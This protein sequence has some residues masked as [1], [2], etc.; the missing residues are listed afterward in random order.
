MTIDNVLPD[1]D[2]ADAVAIP[3]PSVA[4]DSSQDDDSAKTWS[5]KASREPRPWGTYGGSVFAT[6]DSRQPLEPQARAD[7]SHSSPELQPAAA[8]SAASPNAPS[9]DSEADFESEN[10]PH[11]RPRPV[12]IDPLGSAACF[13]LLF[14]HFNALLKGWRKEKAATDQE[15]LSLVAA[16]TFMRLF[17]IARFPVFGLVTSG[18][19]GVL[20][21]AWNEVTTTPPQLKG[22]VP[23]KAHNVSYLEYGCA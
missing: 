11:S 15:R 17:N 13:P 1:K 5:P 4:S 18:P 7:Y 20:S 22:Q 21:S 23:E 3:S 19:I 9:L 8:A 16:C 12:Q 2:V 14:C 10:R 6:A